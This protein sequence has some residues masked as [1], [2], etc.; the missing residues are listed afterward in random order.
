[1]AS[2]KTAKKAA[3]KTADKKAPEV[4]KVTRDKV[5]RVSA[6]SDDYVRDHAAAKDIE[7]GEA[8]DALIETGYKRLG[9][10]AKYD[11]SAKGKAAGSAGKGAKGAAKAR[12]AGKAGKGAKR[13]A[14]KRAPRQRAAKRTTTLDADSA[15]PRGGDEEEGDVGRNAFA[16]PGAASEEE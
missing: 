8:A 14:T 2:K 12:K 15:P 5:L 6:Q 16:T 4:K 1:M 7:V 13:A 11:G 10:L 3:K 9:A